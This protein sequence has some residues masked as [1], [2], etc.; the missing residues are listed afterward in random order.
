MNWSLA[1]DVIQVIYGAA[2]ILLLIMAVGR[3]RQKTE[4]APAELARDLRACRERCDARFLDVDRELGRMRQDL[5]PLARKDVIVVQ[6]EAIDR[7]LAIIE[8]AVGVNQVE[9]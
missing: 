6:L 4:T 8:R 5:D 9:G 2:L 3:F 1:A 7:R